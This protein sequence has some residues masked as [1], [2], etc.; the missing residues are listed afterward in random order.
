M[1]KLTEYPRA[2]SF[3]EGDILI[4]DG[5][6][7]TKKILVSDASKF[8]GSE[9]IMINETAGE[10]TKVVVT[11]TN[12]DVSLATTEDLQEVAENIAEL[13]SALK[14]SEVCVNGDLPYAGLYIDLSTGVWTSHARGQYTIVR[15]NGGEEIEVTGSPNG[16]SIIAA[17]KSYSSPVAG[18]SA[19]LSTAEDWTLPIE[20]SKNG[21]F[22]GTVPSDANYLYVYN[23]LSGSASRFPA[24]IMLD[25]YELTETVKNNIIRIESELTEDINAL[26]IDVSG[27]EGQITAI[28]TN[29]GANYQIVNGSFTGEDNAWVASYFA[30]F[31]EVKP[32]SRYKIT[33]Q[34][35][36]GRKAYFMGLKSVTIPPTVGDTPNFSDATGWTA[37]REVGIGATEEG[38]LPNDVNYLYVYAGTNR[39]YTRL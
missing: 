2:T 25:N 13:K 30:M 36:S 38:Y 7:G 23:G 19:E 11:T 18:T 39:N 35:I 27:I 14:D 6:N 16:S 31:V 26:N 17:L 20:I 10:N 22:S 15:V 33:S 9:I 32:N 34:N 24:K 8:M 12:E 28:N 4:K 29:V 21:N 1:A 37:A 3:D 5:V